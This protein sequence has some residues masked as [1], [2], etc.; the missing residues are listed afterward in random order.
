MHKAILLYNPLA[1]RRRKRRLADVEAALTVLR[2]AGVEAISAATHSGAR[3][4]EQAQEAIESGCDT[5]FACGGDGTIHDVLQGMVGTAAALAIIPLGTANSLAH[6]LRLPQNPALAARVALTAPAHRI[7]VGKVNCLDF[8]GNQTS[9]YFLVV[10]GVGVDAHLF[11]ALSAPLKQRVGMGAYYGKAT[12]LWLSHRME[13]FL[14]EFREPN[15][16]QH[17]RILVS[18]LLAV[19][20]RNFG[21]ILQELAPGASLQRNDLRLV[22]FRTSNRFFY[23]LYVLKGLLRQKWNIR[24]IDLAHSDKI[25]CQCLPASL[26]RNG[27]PRVNSR[28][29]VEADGELLGTLPAEISVVPDA[30]TL[31]IP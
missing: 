21:G 22:L 25:S 26:P 18:E 20:I 23:L 10:T 3:A 11:Y 19:R 30:L 5:V 7:A 9:R 15:V 6:D 12:H 27:N 8:S 24:G 28:I 16:D 17:R 31:L 2:A 14:A 13:S 1:G 4:G 29:F